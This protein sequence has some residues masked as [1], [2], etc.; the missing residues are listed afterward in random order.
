MTSVSYELITNNSTHV[1]IFDA[2]NNVNKYL[3]YFFMQFILQPS[4]WRCVFS[5]SWPSLIWSVNLY[6][7]PSPLAPF[8]RKLRFD[9]WVDFC[10]FYQNPIVNLTLFIEHFAFSK[11][12]SFRNECAIFLIIHWQ[13]KGNWIEIRVNQ[14]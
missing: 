5:F 7:T 2:T 1:L 14:I 13:M 3:F 8:H 4:I 12:H 11:F 6:F 10:M 9:F